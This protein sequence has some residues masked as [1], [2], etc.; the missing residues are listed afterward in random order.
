[1]AATTR[2]GVAGDSDTA[3]FDGE[4]DPPGAEAAA[5][6]LTNRTRRIQDQP[7][8]REDRMAARYAGS[9]KSSTAF[10]PDMRSLSAA[11]TVSS[12]SRNCTVFIPEPAS[13]CG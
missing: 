8:A 10:R 9:L 13:E 11:D 6:A 12:E 3:A 1:M 4:D 2:L 7:A 5:H